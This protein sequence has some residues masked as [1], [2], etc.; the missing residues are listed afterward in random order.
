MV[1]VYSDKCINPIQLIGIISAVVMALLV[2]FGGF[3]L[4]PLPDVRCV[5][6]Y[7]CMMYMCC[8]LLLFCPLKFY[9]QKFHAQHFHLI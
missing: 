2:V 7:F 1:W 3:L 6:V 5:F 9:V 8:N 4:E